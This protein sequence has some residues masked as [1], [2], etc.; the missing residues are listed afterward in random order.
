MQKK[1]SCFM[2][3]RDPAPLRATVRGQHVSVQGAVLLGL[4]LRCART[5]L[6]AR[7]K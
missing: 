2:A 3:G 6:G 5:A 1:L 4:A 7:G